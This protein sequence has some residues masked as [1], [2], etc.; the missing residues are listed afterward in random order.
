MY[1]VNWDKNSEEQNLASKFKKSLRN[2]KGTEFK[3]E[4]N[5]KCVEFKTE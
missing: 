5:L 2:I 1:I 3:T 4:Q